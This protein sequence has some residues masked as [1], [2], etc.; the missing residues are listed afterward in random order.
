[1]LNLKQLIM[2]KYL[3]VIMDSDGSLLKRIDVTN[4]S[5]RYIE[6]IENGMMVNINQL[7]YSTDT[8]ESYVELNLI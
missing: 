2:Y 1:M 3:V 4:K 6:R 7:E 8:I 5:P